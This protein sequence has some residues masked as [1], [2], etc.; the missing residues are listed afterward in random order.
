MN[1]STREAT[2]YARSIAYL[3][4]PHKVRR[5]TLTSFGTAPSLAACEAIVAIHTAPQR[6]FNEQVARR[7]FCA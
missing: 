6:R 5:H 7:G 1:M 2:V 3:R 4:C